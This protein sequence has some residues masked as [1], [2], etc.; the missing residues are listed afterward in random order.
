MTHVPEERLHNNKYTWVQ[1]DEEKTTASA[2]TK[3]LVRVKGSV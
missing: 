1:G 3:D 2:S